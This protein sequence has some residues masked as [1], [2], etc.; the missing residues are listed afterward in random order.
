MTIDHALDW[1]IWARMPSLRPNEAVALTYGAEPRLVSEWTR[2]TWVTRWHGDRF[3]VV[4]ELGGFAN[5]L[6]LLRRTHGRAITPT[7]LARW[8]LTVGW[9]IPQALADL[10]PEIGT[11]AV[12]PTPPE[13]VDEA[14]AGVLAHG[15]SI[16]ALRRELERLGVRFYRDAG[17]D[18]VN[19]KDGTV[20]GLF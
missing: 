16:D 13:I 18:V 12:N 1:S 2:G 4:Y 14:L 19:T 7:A 10:A 20:R 8:A 3:G 6:E 5:R 9:N 11:P 15:A 17:K